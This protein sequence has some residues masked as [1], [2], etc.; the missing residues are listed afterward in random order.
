MWKLRER[1]AHSEFDKVRIEKL[2]WNLHHRTHTFRQKITW[3]MHFPMHSSFWLKVT[4]ND[5]S[6]NIFRN[7]NCRRFSFVAMQ[8]SEFEP[9]LFKTKQ[10]FPWQ[11][12]GNCCMPATTVSA[13]TN[14]LAIC[15]R[16]CPG[17]FP[18]HLSVGNP[19]AG[20]RALSER[21]GVI[22]GGTPANTFSARIQ[23]YMPML[24]FWIS[25]EQVHRKE[26]VVDE[27]DVNRYLDK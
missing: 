4:K 1:L 2:T 10:I 3:F 5:G 16:R 17:M 18:A 26:K 11:Q 19:T 8:T 24:A 22:S 13:E 6:S 12:Y 21:I 15:R 23:R 25:Q 20:T 9:M 7:L 27:R 14:E